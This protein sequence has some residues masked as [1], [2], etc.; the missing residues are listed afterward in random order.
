QGLQASQTG[1]VCFKGKSGRRLLHLLRSAHDPSLPFTRMRRSRQLYHAVRKSL[2]RTITWPAGPL[3][4]MSG[5]LDPPSIDR[6]W[7]H[8]HAQCLTGHTVAL[9]NI[10]KFGAHYQSASPNGTRPVE[11]HQ[12]ADVIA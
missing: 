10:R 8:R 1:D 11:A 6:Q 5:H 3:L 9:I 2:A 12:T 7:L 4:Q